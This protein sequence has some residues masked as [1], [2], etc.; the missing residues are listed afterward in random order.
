VQ[1]KGL[2]RYVA[3]GT[4]YL[5]G[6]F[7]KG[8]MAWFN[9]ANTQTIFASL[10]GPDRPPTYP[11]TCYYLCNSPGNRGASALPRRVNGGEADPLASRRR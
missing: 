7:P 3:N 5:Y 9:P 1:G 8:K 2:Y 10:P 4:R 6:H 11:S